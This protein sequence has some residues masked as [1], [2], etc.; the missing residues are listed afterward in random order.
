MVTCN[1]CGKVFYAGYGVRDDGDYV[2]GECLDA[3][4]EKCN[5]LKTRSAAI[6][7]SPAF[8][9]QPKNRE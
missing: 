5:V 1:E 7:S 2:C 8:N 3:L 9:D 6:T 4:I